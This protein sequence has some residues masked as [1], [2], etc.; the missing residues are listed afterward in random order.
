MIWDIPMNPV[1]AGGYL[2]H[3]CRLLKVFRPE[4]KFFSVPSFLN[5]SICLASFWSEDDTLA[6]PISII[7]YSP[8][9][10]FDISIHWIMKYVN[11]LKTTY[12]THISYI[13]LGYTLTVYYITIFIFWNCTECNFKKISMQKMIFTWR[14]VFDIYYIALSEPMGWKSCSLRFLQI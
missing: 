6:Y 13:L 11:W 14:E 5:S 4:R 3:I 1:S 12:M 7:W 9:K 2:L 8:S 10:V